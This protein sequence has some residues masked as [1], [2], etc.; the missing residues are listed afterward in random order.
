MCILLAVSVFSFRIRT[1]YRIRKVCT[2][3]HELAT[4]THNYRLCAVITIIVSVK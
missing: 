4:Y 3:M 2:V 1:N